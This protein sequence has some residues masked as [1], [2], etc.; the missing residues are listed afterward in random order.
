MKARS[1]AASTG[2]ATLSRSAARRESD[3]ALVYSAS[4]GSRSGIIAWNAGVKAAE[5]TY[6]TVIR[7]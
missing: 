5:A 1:T 3:R 7:A 6:S 2:L 4:S